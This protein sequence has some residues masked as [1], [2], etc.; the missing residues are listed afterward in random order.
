MCL[1]LWLQLFPRPSFITSLLSVRLFNSITHLSIPAIETE[2]QLEWLQPVG[3]GV[4]FILRFENLPRKGHIQQ[5]TR[6][7]GTQAAAF[8][9]ITSITNFYPH[10]HKRWLLE[11]QLSLLHSRYKEGEWQGTKGTHPN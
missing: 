9:L 7:S 11:F 5:M 6:T 3:V 1:G 4:G 10:G 8:W 2:I